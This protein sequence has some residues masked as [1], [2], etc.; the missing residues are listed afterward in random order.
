MPDSGHPVG[1]DA[2]PPHGGPGP[3]EDGGQ[4]VADAGTDGGA[5]ACDP[6]TINSTGTP[7]LG[8]FRVDG[9]NVG[10]LATYPVGSGTVTITGWTYKDDSATQT[11]GFSYTSTVAVG[12]AVKSGTETDYGTT[13]PWA[14]PNGTAGPTVYGISNVTVCVCEGN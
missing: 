6:T 3:Q 7:P 8:C 9:T 2:A 4:A 13:S 5:T 12:Y 14:N 10:L 1:S 11:D